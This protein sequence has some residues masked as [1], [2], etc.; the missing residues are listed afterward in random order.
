MLFAIVPYVIVLVGE[1]NGVVF[2][3]IDIMANLV[4]PE[5]SL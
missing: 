1:D 4:S 5:G 2:F 3:V